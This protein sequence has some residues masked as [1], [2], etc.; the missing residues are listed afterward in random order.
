M[1]NPV[2]DTMAVV[3]AL[4]TIL[5]LAYFPFGV[6][7]EKPLVLGWLP[8]RQ[9]PGQVPAWALLGASAVLAIAYGVRHC[10]RVLQLPGGSLPA[11]CSSSSLATRPTNSGIRSLANNRSRTRRLST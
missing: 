9:W 11:A 3:L 4:E 1:F 10:R 6:P 5:A 2:L 8:W 7:S